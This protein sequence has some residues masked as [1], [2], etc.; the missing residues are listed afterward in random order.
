MSIRQGCDV[1]ALVCVLS[2]LVFISC[3]FRAGAGLSLGTVR[4]LISYW[5]VIVGFFF[6]N[7]FDMAAMFFLPCASESLSDCESLCCC[8]LLYLLSFPCLRKVDLRHGEIA[9]LLLASHRWL[10][11]LSFFFDCGEAAPYPKNQ[12]NLLIKSF[13]QSRCSML[14]VLFECSLCVSLLFCASVCLFL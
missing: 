3:L 5:R 12:C 11:L 9:N 7:Y 14:I 6:S 2:A 8:S 1:A 10:V 4:S 13:I